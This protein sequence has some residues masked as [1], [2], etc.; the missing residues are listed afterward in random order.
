[1]R[2]GL[3]HV[4]APVG[5]IMR[6]IMAGHLKLH[7]DVYEHHA[8]KSVI[9]ASFFVWMC[10]KAAWRDHTVRYK[11]QVIP[12]KRGQFAM[13]V[14]DMAAVWGWSRSKVE[15]ILNRDTLRDM[16]ETHTE[17]G[18]TVITICNYDK[19]QL[20]ADRA[21][22]PS[23][24]PSE[25]DPRQIRDT[26]RKNINTFPYGKGEPPFDPSER[27]ES[28]DVYLYR[29]GKEVLGKSAGGMITKLRTAKGDVEAG[30]IIEAASSKENPR[31]YVSAALS[32]PR[33]EF[34]PE[35]DAFAKWRG[36]NAG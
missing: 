25:T 11:D 4:S 17:T 2:R 33:G 22:T 30:K 6:T 8:F 29:R 15:R 32:T 3:E 1:M 28:F 9:E 26:E 21:E 16:I 5:R 34:Y 18:V 23:G 12:L 20:P 10:S 19:Y 31:E 27:D 36:R 13:S 14:R 35:R 24:T 7:R